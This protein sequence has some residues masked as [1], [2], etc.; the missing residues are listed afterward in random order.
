MDR[1]ATRRYVPL[2]SD[3]GGNTQLVVQ[4]SGHPSRLLLVGLKETPR[5]DT[6]SDKDKKGRRKTPLFYLT[7]AAFICSNLYLAATGGIFTIRGEYELWAQ[8]VLQAKG[9]ES[10]NTNEDIS[11]RRSMVGLPNESDGGNSDSGINNCTS[12]QLQTILKQL[13]PDDCIKNQNQPWLQRCSLN[14]ATKCPEASWIEDH[15]TKLHNSRHFENNEAPPPPFIGIFVGCNKGMDAINALRMGSGNPFFD[16]VKWRNKMNQARI[17]LGKGICGQVFSP[18]FELPG[19]NI[20][21]TEKNMPS[22]GLAQLHCIEPSP[23][24]NMALNRTANELGY[25]KQGFIVAHAALSKLDGVAYFPNTKAGREGK[26]L[27]DCDQST[28]NQVSTKED[29]ECVKVPLYSLDTYVANEVPKDTPINLLSIDAEGF[30]MDVLLGGANSALHRV[31]YLEFEYNWMGSWREQKLSDLIR[32]LDE[33]FA[34]TC[35]W[36][37]YNNTIWR[38]TG[39]FL[40]HYEVHSWSNVACVNRKM[41]DAR[42]IAESLEKLFLATIDRG[43]EIVM[44]FENRFKPS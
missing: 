24:T 36:P 21:A 15:Y 18:Q 1:R 31:Q 39:C 16:K 17:F 9:I 30:D 40:D 29:P 33:K 23:Q 12:E 35:Y 14:Y 10:N 7:F 32:L 11:P 19:D 25:S 27:G 42:N 20:S 44:N 5:E 26:G 8:L 4:R 6:K 28:G 37:G 41:E 34:F 13:P 3:E 22:A 2:A 43:D 38:I